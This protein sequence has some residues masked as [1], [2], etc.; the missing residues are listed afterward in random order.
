MEGAVSLG[1]AL[2]PRDYPQ[3]LAQASWSQEIRQ[4]AKTALTTEFYT[5]PNRIST[6]VL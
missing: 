1:V 5:D 4:H 3:V 2:R 6:S